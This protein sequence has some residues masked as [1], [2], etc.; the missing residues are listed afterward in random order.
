MA[1]RVCE[2]CGKALTDPEDTS[3]AAYAHDV[4]GMIYCDSCIRA[5]HSELVADYELEEEAEK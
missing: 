4:L 1:V 3:L 2:D 5:Y